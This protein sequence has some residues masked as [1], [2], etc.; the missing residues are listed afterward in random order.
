MWSARLLRDVVGI[1]GSR[2]CGGAGTVRA[3]FADADAEDL[4]LLD[5]LLGIRDPAR[6]AARHRSRRA[7]AAVDGA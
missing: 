4:L 1:D 5:D 2:R 7:A 3:R 6:A